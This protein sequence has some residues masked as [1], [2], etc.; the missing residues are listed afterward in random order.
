M[1][2]DGF[3]VRAGERGCGRVE[4]GD[5]SEVSVGMV[6]GLGGGEGDV[7]GREEAVG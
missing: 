5:V 4:V 6:Q 7:R 3:D 2:S 1:G